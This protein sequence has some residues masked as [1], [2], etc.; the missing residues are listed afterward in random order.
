[1]ETTNETNGNLKKRHG[2]VTAWLIIIIIANSIIAAGYTFGSEFIAQNYPGGI[3]NVALVLLAVFGIANIV[4]A[5]MLLKWKKIG[6]WGFVASCIG[7]LAV[8]LSIGISVSQSIWGLIGIAILY[9][10][11][12]IKKDNVSAWTNLD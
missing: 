3:S 5:I 7:I 11:L 2:C 4:S 12:Q 6:F 9:G 1:M 10:V 8:N